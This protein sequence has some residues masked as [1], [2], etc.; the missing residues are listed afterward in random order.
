MRLTSVQRAQVSSIGPERDLKNRPPNL[1][2]SSLISWPSMNHAH[3]E[4]RYIAHYGVATSR[5]RRHVSPQWAIYGDNSNN[6]HEGAAAVTSNGVNEPRRHVF[7][8][9]SPAR[10]TFA[11]LWV[12][13]GWGCYSVLSG[14]EH[15]LPRVMNISMHENLR[16]FLFLLKYPQGLYI[17]NNRCLTYDIHT[18]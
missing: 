18:I 15:D 14:L 5:R 16:S 13:S 12:L 3:D 1:S 6:A 9:L 8:A 7:T 4:P 17:Y 10:M 11:A 2:T